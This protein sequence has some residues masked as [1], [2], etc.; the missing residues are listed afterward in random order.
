MA[1]LITYKVP[2]N[3]KGTIVYQEKQG[4]V[5]NLMVGETKVKFVLQLGLGGFPDGLAHYASGQ[6]FGE[7]SLNQKKIE[8]RL[9]HGSGYRTTNRD[10]AQDIINEIVDRFGVV[11]IME[12][13]NSA[14]V[15]NK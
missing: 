14:P 15:L 11:K 4:Y 1:K 13:L 2:A 6:L 5:A 12:L 9:R 7:K 8:N 10:A 3:D